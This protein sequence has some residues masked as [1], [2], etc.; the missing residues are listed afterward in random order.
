MTFQIQSPRL[1][2]TKRLATVRLWKR[3]LVVLSFVAGWMGLGWWLKLDANR[4]LLLGVP[5]TV[6]FQLLVQRQPLQALWVRSAP[7]LRINATWL[8]LTAALAA[9]PV[10]ALFHEY[11]AGWVVVGWLGCAILGAPVAAYSI[12][13]I[14]HRV[15]RSVW[16]SLGIVVLFALLMVLGAVAKN[17]SAVFSGAAAWEGI[18]STLL[19]FPVCYFLEEVTFRGALD[20]YLYRQEDKRGMPSAMALAFLWGLWHLPIVPHDA[21]LLVT[22]IRLGF[23]HMVIGV[24]LTLSWR[25][26]GNLVVPAAAHA[27]LDGVRNAMQLMK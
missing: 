25:V 10:Y 18:Q 14:T 12:Q 8:L 20:S 3:G 23:F 27:L 9:Y 26:G 1:N 19:Y 11:R 16:P 15:G 21:G 5:L 6:L 7:P 24:P 17:G 13:S 22:A 4:Y 2:E